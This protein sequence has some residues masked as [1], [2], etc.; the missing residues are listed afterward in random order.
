M[1]LS[2][3]AIE[4]AHVRIGSGAGMG[5]KP[6]DW[7]TISLCRTCHAQQHS[8]GETSF[9]RLHNI[10]MTEL[11][12]AFAKASPRAREIEQIKRERS[13]GR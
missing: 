3:A 5:Q 12:E 8:L 4:V 1:C 7:Q 2:T 10:S 9:E 11:A 6:D 13:D